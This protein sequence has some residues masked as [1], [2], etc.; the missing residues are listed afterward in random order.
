MSRRPARAAGSGDA[1]PEEPAP[2]DGLLAEPDPPDP[3]PEPGR[4]AVTAA[5]TPPVL[6]DLAPAPAPVSR[7]AAATVAAAAALGFTALT[8]G[9]A[10]HGAAVPAVDEHLHAWVLA[11]RGP[12][13]A[14][15]A[16]AVRWGGVSWV[17]LPALIPVGAAVAG[18]GRDLA[19]RAGLGLL[20]CLIASTGDFVEVQVNGAVGRLRPPTADWAGAAAGP[21]Y[22]SGHTTAA[23]LF[24]LC[25]GWAL[26]ARVPAG[27]PRRA[28]WAGAAAYAAIVGWSR[29]WLGVHWPTDA[30]GAWLFGAAWVAGSVA[31]IQIIRRRDRAHRPSAHQGEPPGKET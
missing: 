24:A 10:W 12:G 21:S 25:C 9:I 13:S 5:G 7:R 15:V 29:V 28:V 11:H 26:A 30:A 22:P 18:T 8:V 1:R 4:P 14:A 17:V 20:L 31:V 6:P 3:L 16:R 23:T 19:R 2:P 27:W